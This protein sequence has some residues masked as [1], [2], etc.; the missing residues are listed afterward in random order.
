M[1]LFAKEAPLHFKLDEDQGFPYFVSIISILFVT[2]AQSSMDSFV[3]CM[4]LNNVPDDK[5]LV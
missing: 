1:E 4:K 2:I 3:S 5:R